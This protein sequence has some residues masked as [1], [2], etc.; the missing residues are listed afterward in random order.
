MTLPTQFSIRK[1]TLA[2][3]NAIARFNINLAR[4]T[5]GIT[6]LADVISSGVRNLMARPERGFYLVVE[7]ADGDSD[8]NIAASLM[9]TTEWSDWRNG[10]FW[11]IQSVY[12]APAWRRNGLY[13]MMYEQVK[14]LATADQ[15]VC[16]FRLYVEKDNEVAQATYQSMGMLRTH[17][18]MFEELT[19]GREFEET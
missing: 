7:A 15:N 4:E 6:L 13:R 11:W 12:V 8:S 2:D 17:Y 18:Q 9:V 16:G 14:T 1:G 19:P 3:V 5:E 10:T